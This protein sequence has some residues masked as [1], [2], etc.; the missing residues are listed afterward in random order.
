MSINVCKF[1]L[2]GGNFCGFFLDHEVEF[3]FKT[4]NLEI[5]NQML[6]IVASR[7]KFFC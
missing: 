2:S 7:F 4:S 5:R 3:Y 6:M 1:L